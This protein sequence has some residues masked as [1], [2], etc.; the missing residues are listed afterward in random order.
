MRGLQAASPVEQLKGEQEILGGK[1]TEGGR[2]T[3]LKPL[4]G[5]VGRRRHAFLC[6]LETRLG[7]L[8]GHYQEEDR[9]SVAGSMIFHAHCWRVDCVAL[10]A[11]RLAVRLARILGRM[12]FH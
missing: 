6:T 10:Q 2:A 4:T 1:K 12:C 7:M 8:C 11:H 9:S 5:C 3:V